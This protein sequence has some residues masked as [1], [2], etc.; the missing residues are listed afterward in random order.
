MAKDQ[1]IKKYDLSSIRSIFCGAAP[2]GKE[3]A[4]EAEALWPRGQVNVKQGWGMTEYGF[5]QVCL[6]DVGANGHIGRLQLS[7]PG[8]HWTGQVRHLSAN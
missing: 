8:T 4:A 6:L 1:N 3:G 7:Q 2:L 5:A